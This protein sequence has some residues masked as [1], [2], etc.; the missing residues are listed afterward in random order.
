M[1]RPLSKS[2]PVI[3]LTPEQIETLKILPKEHLV[4]ILLNEN[5]SESQES[6]SIP[7]GFVVKGIV[8][9]YLRT[10]PIGGN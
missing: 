8:S 3:V 1:L 4:D 10:S 2:Q 5:K 6:K 9:A 7:P